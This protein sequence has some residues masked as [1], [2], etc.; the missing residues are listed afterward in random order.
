MKNHKFTRRCFL[1]ASGAVAAPFIVPSS[2]LGKNAPS[3]RTTIGFI[4][5]GS[6]GIGANLGN[7]LSYKDAQAVAICDV[8]QK[9]L[10][11]ARDYIKQR[12]ASD[13]KCVSDFREIIS[14]KSIDAVCISTPDH[15]HVPMSLMALEA[16]KDVF[17]EKP[18]LTIAEGGA[19]VEA[20][21]KHKAVFQV[22]LEDRSS[23][24]FHKIIE[25]VRNGA[26]GELKRVKVVLPCGR[27]YPKEQ[28]VKVP[29]GLDYN[30][31]LGPAPFSPYTPS[32]TKPYCWRGI[33]DYSGGMITDW[34]SHLMDTAQL[35]VNAP[36]VCP[37]EVSGTGSTPKNAINDVPST[38]N[39]LY[40]YTNGVEVNVVSSEHTDGRGAE[41][42]LEGTKGRLWKVR[43]GGALQA[44]PPEILRTK[45]S[46]EKSKYIKLPP[47]EQR[48]FLDCVKTRKPT[49][50]TAEAMR[51]L[52][53]TLH[54]GVIAIALGRKLKWDNNTRSFIK[55]DAA[56][57]L[58]SRP[59]RD[60][61]A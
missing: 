27:Y 4:G 38:F 24:H 36:G 35:A 30:M 3:N 48:N 17:C 12:G 18:T 23:A 14:D 9:A 58:Q 33:R 44:D 19:L 42:H 59:A 10:Q 46:P 22:G 34:G 37:V 56:N 1:A 25:W 15:W 20:V 2:V 61:T 52:C 47:C 54:M 49:T 57:Q 41:I 55:D 40:R 39:L 29:A 16:G 60:W 8:R 43:W 21:S 5:M 26:L 7:F 51:D 11:N 45:Y 28:T 32:R 13:C 6:Q 31:W 50:Y 53:N